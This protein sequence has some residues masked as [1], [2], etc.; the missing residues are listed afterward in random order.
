MGRPKKN[1][2][3]PETELRLKDLQERFLEDRNNKK[4]FEEYFLL[5]RTY[6]RSIALK[7]IKRKNIFLQP[8]RVDEICTDATLLLVNQYKKEGWTIG[9]SFAGVLRWK[10]IEAMY[11]HANEEMVYSLNNTFTGDKE[12]KEILDVMGLNEDRNWTIVTGS[13]EEDDPADLAVNYINV[14]FDE[15]NE[16]IDIA[17]EIL[18]Y[19]TFVRFL[20]WL[21]LFFRKPKSR[22]TQLAFKNF[23]I[24]EREEEAFDVILLEVRNKIAQHAV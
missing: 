19:S 20:L 3:P 1:I 15:I 2:E 23:F 6:A 22:N 9:S 12:G 5:L 13:N 21:L 11:K 17:Y 14:S 18:P 10:V 4:V 16:I 24:K 7:E 8:E